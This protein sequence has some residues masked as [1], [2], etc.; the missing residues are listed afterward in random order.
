MLPE[1][2][3]PGLTLRHGKGVAL[4]SKIRGEMMRLQGSY[5]NAIALTS[6]GSRISPTLFLNRPKKATV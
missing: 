1:N 2:S 3:S 5:K 4:E 6:L